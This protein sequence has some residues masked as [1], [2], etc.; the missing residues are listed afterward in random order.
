VLDSRSCA[1][2]AER[3]CVVERLGAG[4]TCGENGEGAL[5]GVWNWECCWFGKGGALLIWGWMGLMI[6]V[7]V[8]YVCM[9]ES[10]C[11]QQGQGKVSAL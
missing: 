1:A 11:R 9:Y 2:G 3:V 5:V 6:F 10:C 7:F 4:W 8:I